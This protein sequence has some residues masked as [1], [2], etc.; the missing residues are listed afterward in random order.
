MLES[1]RLYS[2]LAEKPSQSCSDKLTHRGKLSVNITKGDPAMSHESCNLT[3]DE[4]LER[5][6]ELAAET[7]KNL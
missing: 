1:T 7:L 2:L 3:A 5:L 6:R 4:A